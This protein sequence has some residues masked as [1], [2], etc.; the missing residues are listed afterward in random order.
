MLT[1]AFF[2]IAALWWRKSATSALFSRDERLRD[3]FRVTMLRFSELLRAREVEIA[4]ERLDDALTRNLITG[5]SSG[6]ALF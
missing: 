3:D 2:L 4:W 1:F 6:Y 5:R